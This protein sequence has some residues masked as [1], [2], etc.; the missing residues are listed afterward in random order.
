MKRLL[1]PG[2]PSRARV[3][4][5]AVVAPAAAVGLGLALG[6]ENLAAATALCLLAVVIAAA[7][8]GLVSGIGAAIV[9]FLGLNFFFTEPRHTFVVREAA[10]VVALLA[11][12]LCAL[13]VGALLGRA[14][15]ERSRAER[16]ATE[17]Q[18]LSRTTAKLIS[19]EPFGGILDSFAAA[20]V[21]LFGLAHCEIATANGTG[22]ASAADPPGGD[23]PSITVP[24]ATQS[25]SFGSL[26]GARP[27]GAPEFSPSEL[28][29]LQTL[30]SQTGLAIERAGL[31]EEVRSARLEAEASRLRAGLF[32][33]VTH[34]LRTPLASI[35]ASASGLLAENAH[36]DEAQRKEMLRTVV[37]EADHL[38]QI[39]SNL[40]DLARMR[41]GALVP[42]KQ[43]ILID[44]VIGSVLGRMR[45]A[46]SRVVVRTRIREQLP[47][48]DADPV[49]IQQVLSNLLENAIR[50]SPPGS[51]IQISAAHWRGAVQVRV[52][53]RG[54]GIPDQDRVRVFEE[55]YRR[56]TGSGRGGTGL[57]LA[58]ARAIVIAHGGRIWVEGAPGGG[59]AVLFELPVVAD[60][61]TAAPEVPREGVAP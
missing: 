20:L 34:D 57:G 10:D 46:L 42:S 9:S 24:L 8:A 48:V 3:L 33:S 14:L 7:V 28:E 23:G 22:A 21:E 2:P 47:P 55:F 60:Y 54:P 61:P 56:D 44:E 40:L 16:R 13:I 31:D 37:E 6:P 26:T 12:L 32:S 43:A 58:I 18:F 53:D 25:G 39:V 1:L 15:E 35:K 27:V 45:R 4:V 19:G 29:L 49:Q 30:A 36:Y 41:A 5:V 52:A 17:A 11:F 38:N 59:T 51:E 50:F